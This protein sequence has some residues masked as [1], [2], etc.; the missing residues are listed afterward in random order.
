[1]SKLQ[2][3]DDV[4]GVAD[5]FRLAQAAGVSFAVWVI[6]RFARMRLERDRET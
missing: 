4:G 6:G 5:P 3:A 1:M 2:T